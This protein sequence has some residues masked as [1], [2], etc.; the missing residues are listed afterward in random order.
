MISAFF[1]IGRFAIQPIIA[2]GSAGPDSMP[3]A[4]R[5]MATTIAATIV[6]THPPT[7]TANPIATTSAGRS[8]RM[9]RNSRRAGPPVISHQPARKTTRIACIAKS[10]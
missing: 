10:V 3:E 1:Q 4:W 7:P 6:K 5:I 9:L 2:G 8:W